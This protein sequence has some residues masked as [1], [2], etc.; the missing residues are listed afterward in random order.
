MGGNGKDR[1]KTYLTDLDAREQ[2]LVQLLTDPD[3]RGSQESAARD[4][5]YR[6]QKVVCR[7]MR[8]QRFVRALDSIRAD[9]AKRKIAENAVKR[10]QIMD[11][12]A[13]DVLD[14]NTSPRDRAIVAKTWGEFDGSIGTGGNVTHVNVNNKSVDERDLE[15]AEHLRELRNRNGNRAAQETE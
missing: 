14:P 5:G 15:F 4:A 13:N 12:L 9:I 7:K 10:Q 11:A 1:T 3:Y 6:E 8:D 2:R